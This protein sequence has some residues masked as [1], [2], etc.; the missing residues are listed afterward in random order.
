TFFPVS[1]I[2]RWVVEVTPLYRG[3]VLCRE[4]TTGALSW[5]SVISVV[6]L[7][8]MGAIGLMVVSRRLHKILLS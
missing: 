6:Y 7:T 8:A 2:L 1:G 4:L 3:V 5:D